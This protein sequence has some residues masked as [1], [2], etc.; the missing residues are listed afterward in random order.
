MKRAKGVAPPAYADA[1]A[2]DD[3]ALMRRLAGGDL[4]ALGELYDRYRDDVHRFA[5]HATSDPADAEDIV[6]NVF[7]TA[8]EVAGRFDGRATCRPWLIGITA[9]LAGRRSLYRGRVTRYLTH[10]AS[11]VRRTLDPSSELEARSTLDRVQ[12]GLG[13]MS[14][15][16]RIVLLMA[17]VEGMTCERISQEL[18]IP[19]GTVW[20]RLF[21][22]RKELRAAVPEWRDR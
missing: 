13:R 3:S 20:T 1:E 21:A 15:S 19:L 12:A 8:A 11:I 2:I 9:R 18:A 7:L 17:E 14:P 16:K 4:G 6:Q 22:A 10:W 5:L